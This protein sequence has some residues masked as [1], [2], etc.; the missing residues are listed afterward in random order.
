IHA[1]T[2]A[3]EP[4]LGD[5]T[6]RAK[7]GRAVLALQQQHDQG[8]SNWLDTLADISLNYEARVVL[9]LI[10]HVYDRPGRLA[11]V[12]AGEDRMS[13]VMLN[14]PFV[15]DPRTKRPQA[16]HGPPP[17]GCEPQHYDLNK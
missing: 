17:P 11:R 14:Q 12:R 7:S 6:P 16:L 15:L 9:D 13:C 10:P 2:G 4:T 8:N 1:G 3:Y 5:T